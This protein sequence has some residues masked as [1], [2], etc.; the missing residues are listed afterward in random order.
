MDLVAFVTISLILHHCTDTGWPMVQHCRLFIVILRLLASQLVDS[1][2]FV[3]LS[4]L[5]LRTESVLVTWCRYLVCFLPHPAT[6][7]VCA[8]AHA[9]CRW[10][11]LRQLKQ[12][13]LSRAILELSCGLNLLNSSQWNIEWL[14]LHKTQLVHDVRSTSALRSEL[15]TT[16]TLPTASLL[17]SAILTAVVHHLKLL[18]TGLF[19][20]SACSPHEHRKIVYV[21]YRLL[22]FW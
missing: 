4:L 15:V 7:Q 21:N 19:A 11:L 6:E 13:H 5:L 3:S 20:S 18:N 1:S 22:L 8:R 14:P 16:Q 10:P 2:L 12:K 17:I 9:S